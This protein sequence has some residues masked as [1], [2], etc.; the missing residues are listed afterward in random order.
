MVSGPPGPLVQLLLLT[1]LLGWPQQHQLVVE[2]AAADQRPYMSSGGWRTYP[3]DLVVQPGPC[4]IDIRDRSLTQ[5]EFL[6]KYAYSRPVI[7]RDAADNDLFRALTHRS[8]LLERYGESVVR[9]SSANSYSYE[10]RDI[11]FAS[12]CRDY[13]APQRITTLGNETFYMFGDNDYEEWSDL[14]QEYKTPSYSLPGHRPA[15][16]FGLAGPGSG[17]PFHFH[18]PGFGEAVHGRKR[19]FLTR[20]DV[21]P[22]FHPNRTTLQWFLQDY[23]SVIQEV[24]MYECTIRPGEAI[25]FPDKWWHATL[26]IDTAVFIST[27]L[28]P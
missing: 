8:R 25:Y 23:P 21:R 4:N 19:W 6:A 22:Q 15:L 11:T 27:F 2:V 13:M 5:E 20:P 9:L 18:G 28:S 7:I 10:K 16:S 24:E 3:A 1:L 17:V 26:N 12:Y 14:L